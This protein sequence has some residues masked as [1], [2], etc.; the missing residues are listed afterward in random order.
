MVTDILT[1][2][3]DLLVAATAPRSSAPSRAADADGRVIACPAS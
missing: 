3:T 2:G 1:K